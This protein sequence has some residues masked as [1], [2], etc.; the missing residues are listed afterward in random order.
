MA[1]SSTNTAF[2]YQSLK[3]AID[4]TGLTQ[5]EVARRAGVHETYICALLASEKNPSKK[6]PKRPSLRVAV[7]LEKLLNVDPSALCF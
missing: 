2:R 1:R 7:R 6:N 3:A 5:R 4:A